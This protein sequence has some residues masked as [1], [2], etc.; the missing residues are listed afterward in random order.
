MSDAIG[1]LLTFGALAFVAVVS[2]WSGYLR[3]RRDKAKAVLN[4]TE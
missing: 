1:L 2:Y 4:E 3:G